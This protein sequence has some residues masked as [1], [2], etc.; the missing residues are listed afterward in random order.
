M[1]FQALSFCFINT[2]HGSD[3]STQQ[4]AICVASGDE[5]SLEN[6][7]S[8]RLDAMMQGPVANRSVSKSQWQAQEKQA[9]SYDVF[10]RDRFGMGSNELNNVTRLGYDDFVERIFSNHHRSDQAIRALTEEYLCRWGIFKIFSRARDFKKMVEDRIAQKNEAEGVK[11]RVKQEKLDRQN[12]VIAIEQDAALI[13]AEEKRLLDEQMVREKQ[14]MQEKKYNL[15]ILQNLDYASPYQAHREVALQKTVNQGYANHVQTH[16]VDD[17]TAGMLQAEGI[18]YKQLH[19]LAGTVFQHQLFKEVAQHYKNAAKIMFE[20]SIKNSCMVPHI[21][22]FA[23]SAFDATK[24]EQF[25]LAMQLSDVAELLAETSLS[26][27]KGPIQSLCGLTEALYHPKR[28]AKQ[29]GQALV[30]I[31]R[32]LGG[33]MAEYDHEGSA[34]VTSMVAAQKAFGND[35]QSFNQMCDL[36]KHAFLHWYE[37]S[38][39][40]DKIQATSKLVSDIVLQPFL[41]GKAGKACWGLLSHAGELQVLEGLSCLSE[42]LGFAEIMQDLAQVASKESLITTIGE[43]EVGLTSLVESEIVVAQYGVNF[44]EITEIP[45]FI[46]QFLKFKG[47]IPRA[48]ALLIKQVKNTLK[49]LSKKLD[50]NCIKHFTKSYAQR[51][52]GN[53]TVYAALEHFCNV[54]LE[55]MY[56]ADAGGMVLN[57][58]GGHL[59]G[60]CEAVERAGFVKIKEVVTL[61]SGA[62]HYYMEDIFIGRILEKTVLPRSWDAKKLCD[63]TWKLYDG[64][65]IVKEALHGLTK[66]GVV[67]GIEFEMYCSVNKEAMLVM[68]KIVTCYPIG[69]KKV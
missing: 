60:V 47:V 8:S 49:K 7:T 2:E 36:S 42:E 24:M 43:L 26:I 63:A 65:G 39:G 17:Q 56:S 4:S 58:S 22:E 29:L 9:V 21:L 64:A 33:A 41:I 3:K 48:D 34:C 40:Q 1:L 61:P 45:V 27:C 28:T 46:E 67:D 16:M 32:T 52:M 5:M 50:R 12:K 15:K 62:L 6:S 14:L 18:D 10:C 44:A 57:I 30:P 13:K 51:Q 54:E 69:I 11:Q 55:L 20:Y 38:S 68:H 23:Q 19:D 66:T 25:G 35:M 59:H 53:T 31:L 37:H